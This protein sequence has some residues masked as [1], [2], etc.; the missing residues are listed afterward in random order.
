MEIDAAEQRFL[1][2]N[3]ACSVFITHNPHN[4]Y[5]LS[6]YEGFLMKAFQNVLC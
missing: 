6:N 2:E 1:N 5:C 4:G 3:S